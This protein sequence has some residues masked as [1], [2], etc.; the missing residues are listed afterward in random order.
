MNGLPLEGRRILVTRPQQRSEGLCAAIRAAGGEAVVIPAIEIEEAVDHG[1]L[2]RAIGELESFDWL[3]FT[4]ANAVEAFYARVEALEAAG[5]IAKGSL[6][7]AKRK[8]IAAIGQATARAL[9]GRSAEVSSIPEEFASESIADGLGKVSGMR[10]LIPCSDIAGRRLGETLRMRGAFVDQVVA[11]VTAPVPLA[12]ESLEELERGFDA[13]FFASPSAARNFAALAGG[14]SSLGGAL[15]ICIGPATAEEARK[16]G[17][18]VGL[19]AEVHSAEGLI[20]SLVCHYRD[21][22]AA[23]EES[24]RN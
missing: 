19:V 2:D 7:A 18:R 15:V 10:V 8:R 21:A 3:V 12:P 6:G 11:Y 20:D 23:P 22:A 1:D 17:Y 13:V 14:P 5:R 4:S 24:R 9:R 16:S